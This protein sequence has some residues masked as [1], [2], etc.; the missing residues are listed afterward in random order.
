MPITKET[1]LQ[2][3][4]LKLKEKEDFEEKKQKASEELERKVKEYKESLLREFNVESKEGERLTAEI[5]YLDYL[6]QEEEKERL[7]ELQ[8]DVI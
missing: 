8:E 4:D 7:N 1:L 2:F 5:N 6:I 3:K